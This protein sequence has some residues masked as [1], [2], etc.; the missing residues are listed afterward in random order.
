MSPWPLSLHVV[1]MKPLVRRGF[2][3]WGYIYLIS[4]QRLGFSSYIGFS[5]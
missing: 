2:G 5:V 4:L 3:V 1:R